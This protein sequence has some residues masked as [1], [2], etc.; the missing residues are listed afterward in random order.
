MFPKNYEEGTGSA[1]VAEMEPVSASVPDLIHAVEVR[2]YYQIT[3]A[4]G[5]PHQRPTHL[6]S[7]CEFYIKRCR[8]M[9]KQLQAIQQYLES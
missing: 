1:V 6:L 7:D 2:T 8:R 5:N 3:Q 9:A 4:A